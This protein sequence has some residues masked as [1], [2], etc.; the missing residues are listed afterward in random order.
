MLNHVESESEGGEGPRDLQ[1]VLGRHADGI[2]GNAG[3][4]VLLFLAKEEEMS[5][6]P[7]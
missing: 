6:G 7:N 4:W 2:E 5:P 3:A 1:G